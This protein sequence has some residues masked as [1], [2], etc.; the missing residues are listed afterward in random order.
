M[1]SVYFRFLILILIL[2]MGVVTFFYAVGNRQLQLAV[3][4]VTSLAYI[5]WG[6]IHHTIQ[7][8]LHPKVVIEYILIG[9]IAIVL[10]VT[11]LI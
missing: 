4:I 5:F 6:I 10:L 1:K 7:K 3:G 8:D 9:T 11:V 2:T